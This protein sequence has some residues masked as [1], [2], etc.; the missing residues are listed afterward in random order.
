[1]KINNRK[2]E[3]KRNKMNSQFYT[4]LENY[5]TKI[6]NQNNNITITH[7][8]LDDETTIRI[9]KIER[10]MKQLSMK[11]G[12]V[13]QYA[14]GLLPDYINLKQ[15]HQTGMD[16]LSVNRHEIIELKSR[17]NT[18][19]SGSRKTKF[20]L[21]AKFKHNHPTFTCIYACINADT[22]YKTKNTT[23]QMIIHNGQEIE[24]HTGHKFLE[25]VFGDEFQNVVN[26][27]KARMNLKIE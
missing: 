23:K 26:F 19:N 7:D 3:Y 1:M 10:R 12:N 5:I 20:D 24:I 17:T 13:Y 8:I 18:D 27:I 15:G 4:D 11:R 9:K 16:L 21:L 22:Q 14:I 25:H 6:M 2:Y